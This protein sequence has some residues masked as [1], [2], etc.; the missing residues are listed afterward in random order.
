MSRATL[1]LLMVVLFLDP[2]NS[3]P[4]LKEIM[5]T[6]VLT[7]NLVRRSAFTKVDIKALSIFLFAAF[8]MLP[9]SFLI[10]VL[11]NMDLGFALGTIKAFFFAPILLVARRHPKQFLESFILGSVLLSFF[12]L[13]VAANFVLGLDLKLFAWYRDTSNMLIGERVYGSLTIYM[14]YIKT[15]PLLALSLGIALYRLGQ[16]NNL[17]WLLCSILFLVVLIL[18][19]TRANIFSAVLVVMF[20]VLLRFPKGLRIP[21]FLFVSALSTVPIYELL[22]VTFL[23]SQEESLVIKTGHLLSYIELFYTNPLIL[24]FGQGLGQAFY[25]SGYNASFY[26]TELSY[27]ELVRV[28]GL[29]VA[30]AF[31]YLAFRPLL[32]RRMPAF[33]RVGAMSYVVIAG[34]NPLLLSSTG[35]LALAVIYVLDELSHPEP[36]RRVGEP[37]V[38][39]GVAL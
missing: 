31:V 36:K 25:S 18:S 28:F 3:I 9:L 20:W 35:F 29:P 21:A 22:S 6:L 8:Y 17:R 27:F 1:G 7:E 34:T 24:Y 32:S 14:V 12:S 11:G 19:G 26:N 5:Y 4:G 30:F 33:I 2:A 10:G 39:S 23:N 15:T 16:E 37:F 13:L 38:T